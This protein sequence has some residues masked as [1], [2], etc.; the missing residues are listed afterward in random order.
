MNAFG[1]S[2]I[3]FLLTTIIRKYKAKAKEKN[4]TIG[5]K[6]LKIIRII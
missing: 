2:F 6:K 4:V 1:L 3:F 5:N